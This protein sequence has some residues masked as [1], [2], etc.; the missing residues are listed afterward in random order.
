[1]FRRD[2]TTVSS[3]QSI[4]YPQAVLGTTVE[5]DTLHGNVDP[6]R[7]GGDPHGRDFRVRGQGIP[8][9]DGSGKGD[10]VV[11]VE[12]EVPSPRNLSDE[13]VQLLR[14]LAEIA[15]HPV[16]EERTVVD[17]VKNLFG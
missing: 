9:L 10:H 8:R 14:R 4:S 13:E 3:R 6:R 5:V 15:G 12:V 1:M 2:G 16:K 17:R 7:A 11:T